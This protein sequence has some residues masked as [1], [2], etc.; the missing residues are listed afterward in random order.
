MTGVTNGQSDNANTDI[1]CRPPIQQEAASVDVASCTMAA[2][3]D[4]NE[5]PSRPNKHAVHGDLT[6][7]AV[8]PRYEHHP[9]E[10]GLVNP[11][12]RRPPQPLETSAPSAT[13]S[14]S[15]LEDPQKAYSSTKSLTS[16]DMVE[17]P[18][19]DALRRGNGGLFPLSL[20]PFG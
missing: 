6:T 7:A 8:N 20:S 15:V 4:P 5:Q 17:R 18:E 10:A 1:S 13:P 11:D 14:A 16:I 3:W 2:I 12:L 19:R 9:R